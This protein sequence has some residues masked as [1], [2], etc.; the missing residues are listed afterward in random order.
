MKVR[1]AKLK[2]KSGYVD[3]SDF[4]NKE[5]SKDKEKFEPDWELSCNECYDDENF[6]QDQDS[7][8]SFLIKFKAELLSDPEA[9]KQGV[10]GFI[11]PPHLNYQQDST[12]RNTFKSVELNHYN[13]IFRDVQE[14][15]QTA[16]AVFQNSS[17]Q[18]RFAASEVDLYLEGVYLRQDW[19][20]LLNKNNKKKWR[21]Y[22]GTLLKKR[23]KADYGE[24]KTQEEVERNMKVDPD[25]FSK[26]ISEIAR[27]SSFVEPQLSLFK[28]NKLL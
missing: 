28:A 10:A 7:V 5:F 1:A 16:Q 15:Q 11:L 9:V 27:Y 14:I 26:L 2:R 6:E 13:L 23:L 8:L 22:L 21:Q 19:A 12:R 24:N 25:G 17:L 18:Q 3:F 20:A 4:L